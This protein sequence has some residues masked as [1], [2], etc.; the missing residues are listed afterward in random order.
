L[1]RIDKIPVVTEL[2][3]SL[4]RSPC[5]FYGPDRAVERNE[6]EIAQLV[7]FGMF[8]WGAAMEMLDG[9]SSE[10]GATE[11]LEMTL[12]LFHAFQPYKLED[13]RLYSPSSGAVHTAW[14]DVYGA[15]YA[16]TD[17]A[18]VVISNTRDK[19]RKSVVWTVKPENLG[20]GSTPTRVTVKDTKSGEVQTLPLPGLQDGSLSTELEGYEYRIFEVRPAP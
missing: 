10:S 17:Q 3:E 19:P 15:V 11:A 7:L 13:Y 2:A 18:L 14:E 8:P 20:F 5:P 12:K 4:P 16:K 6:D 9:T 1:L